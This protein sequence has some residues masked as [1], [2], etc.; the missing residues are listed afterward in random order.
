MK[1][2][3]VNTDRKWVLLY[4]RRWLSAPLQMSD[5]TVAERD[6]GMPT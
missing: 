2:V 4:V 1:A 6:R 3:E 5:G